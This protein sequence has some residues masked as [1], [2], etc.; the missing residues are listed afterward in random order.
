LVVETAEQQ[1][2]MSWLVLG[3]LGTMLLGG[4]GFLVYKMIGGGKA[5]PASIV[6]AAHGSKFDDAY[7]NARQQLLRGEA[8]GAAEAFAKLGDAK[9]TRPMLDWVNFHEALAQFRAGN[10]AAGQNA[11]RKIESR[12]RE[13]PDAGARKVVNFLVDT[14]AAGASSKP[15]PMNV[16]GRLDPKNHEA[17]A[18]L[19]F[20][21]QNW[22]LQHFAEAD[23][24]LG[25]FEATQP[26][27]SEWVAAYKPLI[28]DYLSDLRQYRD[29]TTAVKM[30]TTPELKRSAARVLDEAKKNLKAEGGLRD[31]L[32]ALRKGLGPIPPPPPPG[33]PPGPRPPPKKP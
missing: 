24:F 31:K 3:L 26:M 15:V 25:K 16:A 28:A 1:N 32:N 4:G 12:G 8:A 18:L 21:L 2:A 6:G 20:G 17:L 13:V 14:A 29:A 33:K 22:Q 27:G 30:A 19:L 7:E 23:F 11:L 5:A 9:L 10:L